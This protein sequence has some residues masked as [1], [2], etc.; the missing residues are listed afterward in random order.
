MKTIE[1]LKQLQADSLVFFMKVHN[2]HWNVRG[3]SF[4]QVHSATEE[5]YEEFATLFDDLAE[6]VIQL[7]GTPYVTIAE[8]LKVSKVQEVSQTSFSANEVL[9]GVINEYKYFQKALEELSSVADECGDK[10]TGAFADD[11]V[12]KLQKSIWML[13][14]QKA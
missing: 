1:L 5:I 4:P 3:L 11:K 6:R 14:A 9:E 7:G 13:N 10:V 12:A 2:Y 8:C